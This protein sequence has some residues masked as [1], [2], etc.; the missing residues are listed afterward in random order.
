[1]DFLSID[2]YIDDNIDLMLKDLGEL[3][4]IPS[5]RGEPCDDMPF[6][7]DCA[8]VIKKAQEQAEKI[9]LKTINHENYMLECN[10]NDSD[11]A[12]GV[13]AHLDVV[14]EGNGWTYEPFKLSV[15]GNKAIGRGTIDDKGPAEAVLYAVK[16]LAENKVKLSKNVRILLGAAEETGMEDL[17]YYR[18][19]VGFP[20]IMLSP[21]AAFPVINVEKGLCQ[22]EFSGDITKETYQRYIKSFKSGSVVNA[23]PDNASAEVIGVSKQEAD[24]LITGENTTLKISVSDISGGV[25]IKAEGKSAHASTP[26]LGDNALTGLVKVLTELR[27]D[28]KIAKILTGLYEFFPYNEGSGEHFGLKI[29][30]NKSGPL[31]MVL[32][33]LNA[34]D[35]MISGGIDI[36]FPA[37]VPLCEIKKTVS[38]RLLPM[39]LQISYTHALEGHIVDDNEPFIK[40]LLSAYTEVTGNEG[41]CLSEGGA[42]YLHT[43]NGGVAFGAEMPGEITNMHGA[44]EQISIDTLKA[45]SKIYARAIY[46]ICR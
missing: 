4:E 7:K 23:V 34:D 5:K 31:T 2:R 17:E 37:T 24:K 46:N 12:L 11:T 43:V 8:E 25:L 30:D 32:S 42:T 35:E 21:D 14:P 27:L 19:K 38:S 1:M 13:I 18:E 39:G 6:G 44:N 33:L 10:Y 9:G 28:G 41:T 15:V 16:A 45:I 40:T 29:S 36:R 22:L 20:P 3:I 26:E